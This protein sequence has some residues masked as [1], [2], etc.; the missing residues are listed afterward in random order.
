L[1]LEADDP[2]LRMKKRAHKV[3][4][5]MVLSSYKKSVE[6]LRKRQ[7]RW[8]LVQAL[9]ELGSL[10]ISEGLWDEAEEN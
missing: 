8:L 1:Q 5:N 2:S 9:N 6:I 7:E 10:C 3:F 4:A